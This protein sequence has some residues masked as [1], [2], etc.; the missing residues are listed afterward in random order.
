[1][2]P[3]LRQATLGDLPPLV[4]LRMEFMATHT[5]NPLGA[6]LPQRL[7]AHMRKHLAAGTLLIWLAESQ[8][9]TLA[10]AMMD[11]YETL[12]SGG[13]PTGLCGT[14]KN[15]YT[16]PDFR[17]QGLARALLGKLLAQAKELGV[18]PVFLGA[19]PEGLPL[20]E[21]LGFRR[22]PSYLRLDL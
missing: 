13:N 17:R 14:I 9:A 7:A 6:D 1:M 12:P 19:T 3:T 11:V 2:A 22:L 15:V 8:G 5:S 10:V 20:Y 4:A 18:G 21:G 16:L